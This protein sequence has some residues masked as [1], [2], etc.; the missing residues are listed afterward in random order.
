MDI[1]RI[2]YDKHLSILG[3]IRLMHEDFTSAADEEFNAGS[4]LEVNKI[5]W[6]TEKEGSK[7]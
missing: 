7:Q 5:K 3:P 6:G 1:R 2:M 4:R